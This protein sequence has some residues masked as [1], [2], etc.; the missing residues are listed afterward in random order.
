MTLR[1]LLAELGNLKSMK[2]PGS[3]VRI[4]HE[5]RLRQEKKKEEALRRFGKTI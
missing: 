4:T 1:Q 3:V 2:P 5:M